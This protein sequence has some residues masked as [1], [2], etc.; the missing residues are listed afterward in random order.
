MKSA[1]HTLAI[2]TSA[3]LFACTQPSIT[4]V[5]NAA[6]CR[7]VMSPGSWITIMGADLA[8]APQTAQSITLPT[9]LGGV[10]SGRGVSEMAKAMRPRW[11]SRPTV[12]RTR[13]VSPASA[14]VKQILLSA[15]ADPGAPASEQSA[16]LQTSNTR[17]STFALYVDGVKIA[18]KN[19]SFAV[20]YRH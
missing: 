11:S 9:T 16:G 4:S 5:V 3:P 8:A 17:T 13:G 6:S 10:Y 19:V 2:L 18:S 15:A 7:A 20:P 1:L 14:L 12:R